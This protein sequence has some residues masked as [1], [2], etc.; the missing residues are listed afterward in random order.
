MEQLKLAW[1][2]RFWIIV[3]IVALLPIVSYFVDTRKLASNA[4]A[5]ANNLKTIV[6]E[7]DT[8]AK[9]SNPNEKWS[10]A[11]SVLKGELDS[12]VGV[13]HVDLYKKQVEFMT[14]PKA[15]KEAYVAAGEVDV[16]TRNKYQEVFRDQFNDLLRIIDP[17]D[18]KGK[19]RVAV[20]PLVIWKFS[21][22]WAEEGQDPPTVAEAWLAQEDIWL[23]RAILGVVARANKDSTEVKDSAVKQIL[24]IQIGDAAADFTIKQSKS[25]K[26]Q[27]TPR[28]DAPVAAT[29]TA[30]GELRE[31]KGSLYKQ[32]PV[33]ITMIVDQPR[34]REVLAEFGNSEIPMQVKQVEFSEIAI[35]ER[36]KA[37]QGLLGETTKKTDLSQ[38]RGLAPPKDDEFFQMAEIEVRARAIFY[39]KPKKIQ[40]DEDAAKAAVDKA[41]AEQSKAPPATPG[42]ATQ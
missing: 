41:K 8:A 39:N 33:S 34:L 40:D 20:N 13:A 3:G 30:K 16:N 23:V 14:W 24:D 19:G 11:V 10:E 42:G 26:E 12:K 2:Y 32:I 36:D 35:D 37:R 15:V 22:S 21:K 27:L 25:P 18:Q 1:V 9:G 5:Q 28:G 31:I 6:T 7:L 38:K 4:Q 29:G 17:V